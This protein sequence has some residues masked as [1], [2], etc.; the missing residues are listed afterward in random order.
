M[1]LSTE[2]VIRPVTSWWVSLSPVVSDGFLYFGA[3]AFALLIGLTSNEPAQWHWGYISFASYFAAS[4]FL[5]V[6]GRTQMASSFSLRKIVL[7][8]LVLGV[9]VVP[10][11]LETHWRQ[12]NGGHGYA[13]PEVSVIERSA[14]NVVKGTDPYTVDVKN[15]KVLNSIR[16]LPTY[17]SFFPYFPLM[18]VFGLPDAITH[19]GFGL[20]DARIVMSVLTIAIGLLALRLFRTKKEKKIRLA[21]VLFALPTGALFLA[22]GGDDMPILALMLLSLV[23]LQRKQIYVSAVSIGIASAMKLT[24]WPMALGSLLALR[25]EAFKGK[26]KQFVIV[27]CAIVTVAIVPFALKAPHAFFANVFEF[28]LGLS[29]VTSPAASALPGHILASWWHPFKH[30]LPAGTLLIGGYFMA[31]YFK[32]H[33]PLTLAKMLS[34]LSVCFFVLMCVSSATRFGYI[35]YPINFALWSWATREMI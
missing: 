8:L 27:V 19:R 11:G 6:G 22:T 23:A 15:G 29:H 9:V 7:I 1:Q 25:G 18:S 12:N 28:P 26:W 20:T 5:F 14:N 16:G 32:T 35:I 17:E 30:I 13:Q 33:W 24:A 10:L 2:R 3:G 4:L 34:L 21:Q 31:K